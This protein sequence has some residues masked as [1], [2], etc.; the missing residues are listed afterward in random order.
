M[1]TSGRDAKQNLGSRI[2][3]RRRLSRVKVSPQLR[4]IAPLASNG[5]H[6]AKFHGLIYEMI[7]NFGHLRQWGLC[8]ICALAFLLLGF[9]HKAP[10]VDAGAIPASEIA[11]FILPDG[12]L[13]MLCLSSGD[14]KTNHHG[15]EA[16]GFCETCR[17]A[18]ATIL[19]EPTDSW[20]ALILREIAHSQLETIALAPP[21]FLPSGTSAR[22]PPPVI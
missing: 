10:V 17:L 6:F 16:T 19:P 1:L 14:G 15:Q 9:A 3:S 11:A 2:A 5:Y 18:A 21:S 4:H 20:G 22:G 7:R 13:P 8:V 12:S